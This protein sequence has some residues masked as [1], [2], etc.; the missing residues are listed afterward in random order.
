MNNKAIELCIYAIGQLGRPYWLGGFGQEAT[1]DLYQ[2]TKDRLGINYPDYKSQLGK[3]VHDCCGLVKGFFW[4]PDADSTKYTYQKT[5]PDLGVDGQ[6]DACTETGD[7]N[8]IPEIKGI[9]VF[10]QNMSHMGVY[11]GN[12]EVIEARGHDYGVVKTKLKSRNWAKWGKL[13]YL[14]YTDAEVAKP[15]KQ[16]GNA[17]IMTFQTWINKYLPMQHLGTKLDVDGKFG[18]LTRKAAIKCLQYWLNKQY[19]TGLAVDGGYGPLTKAA[20]KVLRKGSSG[21]GVYILQGL[22]YCHGYDPKGFDGSFGVYG[23]EGCLNA[24]KAFQ[25]DNGLEVDGEAG[26]LTFENLCV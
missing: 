15:A 21:D 18:P 6:F 14:D 11:I 26:P 17:Q 23:G 2:R 12:D 1:E 5:M 8:T 16:T 22:L 3:K 10:T 9:L 19:G 24:V 20:C 4:T 7:I 13:K 25:A